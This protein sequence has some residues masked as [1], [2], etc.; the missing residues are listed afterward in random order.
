MLVSNEWLI[1]DKVHFQNKEYLGSDKLSTYNVLE[2]SYS[3]V[4]HLALLFQV[5]VKSS[6][7]I[8]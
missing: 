2:S 1:E 8:D 4:V 3:V 5:T 6:N 7:N